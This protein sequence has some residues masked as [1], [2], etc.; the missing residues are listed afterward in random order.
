MKGILFH[1]QELIPGTDGESTFSAG[2]SSASCVLTTGSGTCDTCTGNISVG[3]R[4]GAC[5]E[6]FVCG[7]TCTAGCIN[8][9]NNGCSNGGCTT[10][11]GFGCSIKA[12]IW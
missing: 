1:S 8:V 11:C 12:L 10:T 7:G 3:D 9:C 5:V 6:G 4:C 2:C